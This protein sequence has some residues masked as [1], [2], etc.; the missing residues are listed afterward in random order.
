MVEFRISCND[1]DPDQTGWYEDFW[2][3][4]T[5]GRDY[6]PC[7]ELLITG[8]KDSV[9]IPGSERATVTAWGHSLPSF[10]N[11]DIEAYAIIITREDT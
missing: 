7:L 3:A 1:Y 4:A 9:V 6:P 10:Y 8:E 2:Y 11:E 5:D